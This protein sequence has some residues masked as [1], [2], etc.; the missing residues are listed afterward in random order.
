MKTNLVLWKHIKHRSLA[1][2]NSVVSG[3]QHN[4][5]ILDEMHGCFV[6]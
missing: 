4:E 5:D 6:E 2:T 3:T 1:G